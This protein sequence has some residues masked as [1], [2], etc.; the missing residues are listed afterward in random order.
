MQ[1]TVGEVLF[2]FSGLMAGPTYRPPARHSNPDTP[3][4]QGVNKNNKI[5]GLIAKNPNSTQPM[6]R[7]G[8]G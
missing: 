4:L 1:N 2:F 7:V 5:D 8:P 3:L 6:P